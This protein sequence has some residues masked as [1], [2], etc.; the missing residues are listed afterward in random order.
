MSAATNGGRTLRP[1]RGV[2]FTLIILFG[3]SHQPPFFVR[4]VWVEKNGVVQPEDTYEIGELTIPTDSY[5][6]R[7]YM[8][9]ANSCFHETELFTVIVSA[10]FQVFGETKQGSIRRFVEVREQGQK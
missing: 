2:P 1:I 5:I 7:R 9:F 8:L 4:D 10:Q 3:H 6:G